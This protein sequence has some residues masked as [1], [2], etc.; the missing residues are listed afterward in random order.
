MS[1]RIQIV[2]HEKIDERFLAQIR[3]WADEVLERASFPKSLPVLH[4]LILA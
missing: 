2:C 3:Y 4:P 1:E